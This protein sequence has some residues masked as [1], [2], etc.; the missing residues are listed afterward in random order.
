MVAMRT[1]ARRCAVA[2]AGAASAAALTVALAGPASAAL[3][4]AGGYPAA[5][6][7]GGAALS[8]S[9]HDGKDAHGPVLGSASLTCFPTG[10][11]HP[12][13]AAAC[14]ALTAAGGW[15]ER[16]K[17]R[18]GVCPMIY[19][20]VIAVGEG[21]WGLRTVHFS[22]VYSNACALGNGLWPVFEF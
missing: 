21:H 8:L 6:P 1:K 15:F 5:G 3:A 16:L 4:P 11:S 13:G 22:K 19:R 17:G 12:H 14:R 10:G 18:T 2:A 7:I 9:V 20:P